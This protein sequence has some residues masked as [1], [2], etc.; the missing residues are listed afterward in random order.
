MT[1]YL[2]RLKQEDGGKLEVGDDAKVKFAGKKGRAV[3]G[4]RCVGGRETPGV[5]FTSRWRR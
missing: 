2:G 5:G 4:F 1:T 3:A